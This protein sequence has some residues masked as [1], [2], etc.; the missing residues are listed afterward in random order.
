MLFRD[1]KTHT[2]GKP[3]VKA[4]R[5]RKGIHEEVG[6]CAVRNVGRKPRENTLV[7]IKGGRGQLVA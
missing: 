4:A 3:N 1:S 7:K 5:R 2:A 6:E